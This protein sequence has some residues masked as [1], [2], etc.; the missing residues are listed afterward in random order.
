MYSASFMLYKPG[1]TW[2][3]NPHST[4]SPFGATVLLVVVLTAAA[5]VT[6][7]AWA[8]LYLF[9]VGGK[10]LQRHLSTVLEIIGCCG[11][12]QHTITWDMAKSFTHYMKPV[13]SDQL[14][15]SQEA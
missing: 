2:K 14:K 4:G 13:K 10:C 7:G 1:L 8:N 12:D 3:S 6:L 9:P 15:L 11:L 5:G